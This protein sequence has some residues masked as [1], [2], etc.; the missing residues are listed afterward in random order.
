M[1]KILFICESYYRKPSPNGIC[2]RSIA[3]EMVMS[4]HRVDVVTL[5]SGTQ[6]PPIER[7]NGVQIH[8]VDPGIIKRKLYIYENKDERKY[9]LAKKILSLNA[10]IY[11]FKY[12]FLS[13]RQVYNLFIKAMQLYDINSY[14]HVVVV[15]HQIHPVLAGIEL[16]K[17]NPEIDLVLY[18]LDAISGG[19][20]PDIMHS[21]FIFLRSLKRWEKYFFSHVDRVFAMESHRG[22]YASEEYNQYRD[23]IKYLDI[24]LLSIN[25]SNNSSSRRNNNVFHAVFTGSM[26]KATADPQYLIKLLPFLP[27]IIVDIYGNIGSEILAEIKKAQSDGYRII[28]H[29][30]IEHD[31]ILQIQK[32][33]DI[34]L[35]FGNA[36]PNM[37][38]CKIFEY[39]STMNKIV[40]FTHAETDSSLPYMNKYDAALIIEEKDGLLKENAYKINKFLEEPVSLSEE[41]IKEKFKKNLPSYFIQMLLG[42]K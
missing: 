30:H 1:E 23:K 4:G 2:I 7:V 33:A 18:T 3:E 13:K 37:I 17:I 8:R 19:W 22:G 38:P 11:A 15:Y 42:E 9:W 24:P 25:S 27:N 34:L 26:Q 40:S 41:C 31:D 29:G 21:Y 6:Q 36:N 12:P 28:V 14:Q 39:M 16:K 20:I 35:N 5:Y 32:K 10:L